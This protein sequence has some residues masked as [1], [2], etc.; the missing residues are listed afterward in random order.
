MTG[1]IQYSSNNTVTFVLTPAYTSPDTQENPLS[2]EQLQ[3]E[4][5]ENGRDPGER[6]LPLSHKD[7][8]GDEVACEDGDGGD[9]DE[10][11]DHGDLGSNGDNC[12]SI[13]GDDGDGCGSG[14]NDGGDNS[15]NGHSHLSEMNR[16]TLHDKVT[17]MRP[18][19]HLALETHDEGLTSSLA[20]SIKKLLQEDTPSFLGEFD[21]LRS[22]LKEIAKKKGKQVK[23]TH[24]T[25]RYKQLTEKIGSTVLAKQHELEK[26]IA[27]FES[28]Y[29]MKHGML[30]TKS[31]NL[32]YRNLLREK[33]LS[34]AIL[35]NIGIHNL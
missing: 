5:A 20:N 18:H 16:Q 28:K 22:R 11:S 31:L 34:T 29:F 24:V 25:T 15:T 1:R 10:H 14:N 26:L 3:A 4:Q 7:T 8:L 32:P 9:H 2:S 17:T 12:G 19:I 13:C 21:T 27:D 33:N 30:P 6:T 23:A 35:R